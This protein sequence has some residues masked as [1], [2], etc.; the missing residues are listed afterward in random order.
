MQED[1]GWPVQQVKIL[2]QQ[3]STRAGN[4]GKRVKNGEQEDC[5]VEGKLESYID[6]VDF[7]PNRHAIPYPVIPRHPRVRSSMV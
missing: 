3:S 2:H 4:E 6:R 5:N 1:T 7:F